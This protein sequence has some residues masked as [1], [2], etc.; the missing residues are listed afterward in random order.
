MYC[1]E[2]YI[3]LCEKIFS[4]CIWWAS[5]ARILRIACYSTSKI[6]DSI[7]AAA[8]IQ[9]I[10]E[11]AS[12]EAENGNNLT[13][14]CNA[15]GNPLPILSWVYDNQIIISSSKSNLSRI[16]LSSDL[17]NNKNL[18]VASFG[19]NR[20]AINGMIR[21]NLP[22]TAVI[23][24]NLN[25]WPIGVHR[26]D[27]LAFNA[28]GNVEK[29]TFMEH[30][31]KPTFALENDTSIDVLNGLPVLLNCDVRGYPIP[32]IFWQKVCESKIVLKIYLINGANSRNFD[33]MAL[34]SILNR[35]THKNMP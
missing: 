17:E 35:N 11:N 7:S 5:T 14:T 12:F 18:I 9:F 10:S 23:H 33:R 1:I 22:Y 24:I 27:C 16:S 2:R 20:N 21:Y 31:L 29:S 6:S 13:F 19:G 25:K 28:Y 3:K 15:S 32:E 30:T 8:K 34:P 26:F 4:R